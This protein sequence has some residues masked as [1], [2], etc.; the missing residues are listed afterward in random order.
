MYLTQYLSQELVS[1]IIVS[2]HVCRGSMSVHECV[3]VAR[4]G[5]MS[6]HDRVR[7]VHIDPLEF[8]RRY[9]L[10]FGFMHIFSD[11]VCISYNYGAQKVYILPYIQLRETIITSR[12]HTTNQPVYFIYE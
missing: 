11:S 1:T 6:V 9:L 3:C 2:Y 4:R 7:V 10:H 5:S 12:A 8:G